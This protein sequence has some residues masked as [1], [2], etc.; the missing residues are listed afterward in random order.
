MIKQFGPV[1]K[2][3]N[4]RVSADSVFKVAFDV[5][6]AGRPGSVNRRLE[7]AAR[8]LNMHATAG[9][10]AENLSVAI[11]V[12]GAAALDLTTDERYGQANANA[13]LIKALTDA[14]V[15][16]ELCGQTAAYREIKPRDLLPGV[17][18]ALSAMTAHARLQQNEYTLNPF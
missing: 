16:I 9:V 3:P 13:P 12:H 6:D 5:A 1:A 17:K 7:S 15:S 8:F 10:P 18:M 14:G 2:V 4:H 11:V